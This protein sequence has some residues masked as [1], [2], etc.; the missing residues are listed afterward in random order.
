MVLVLR[1]LLVLFPAPTPIAAGWT[2]DAVCRRIV[3]LTLV[4]TAGARFHWDGSRRRNRPPTNAKIRR[5]ERAAPRDSGSPE[6]HLAVN[7]AE[8]E[9]DNFQP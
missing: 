3:T 7:L 9:G 6:N 2:H 5:G 1:Q 4:G 8:G